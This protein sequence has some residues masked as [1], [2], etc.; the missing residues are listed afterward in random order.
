MDEVHDLRDAK[1]ADIVVLITVI[2]SCGLAY[3]APSSPAYGFQECSAGCLVAEWAHP[4]R[5]ELGHNLGSQHYVTDTYGYFSWSSGHRF[6]PNPGENEI[7]TAMGGNNISHF[8]NPNVNYGISPTG[9]PIGPDD[10]A[11]NF[12]AFM[13]TVPMVADFRCS[14]DVCVGDVNLDAMVDVT[15]L[16]Q[17]VESWGSCI[18]CDADVVFDGVV[19]VVDL[20]RVIDGWGKCN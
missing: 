9:V 1:A 16:L 10:E 19:D 14:S 7:G 18:S 3:V 5:H 20:L 12:S 2:G 13:V 8:S 4:F 6:I 17:V 11:D 15:D